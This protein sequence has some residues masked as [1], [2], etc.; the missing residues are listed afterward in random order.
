MGGDPQRAGARACPPERV[1]GVSGYFHRRENDLDRPGLED[2]LPGWL[3]REIRTEHPRLPGDMAHRSENPGPEDG[4]VLDLR[5]GK[6]PAG[7]SRTLQRR[8]AAAS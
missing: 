3:R 2:V 7:A 5:A 8:A 6:A 1:A 4:D